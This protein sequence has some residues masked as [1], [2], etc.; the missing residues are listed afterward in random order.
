[1]EA[2]ASPQTQT[3]SIGWATPVTLL[4]GILLLPTLRWLG[5]RPR[6]GAAVARER[7]SPAGGSH[8]RS[9]RSTPAHGSPDRRRPISG[10]ATTGVKETASVGSAAA[11]MQPARF[12]TPSIVDATASPGE[13]ADPTSASSNCLEMLGCRFQ[14]EAPHAE[15][16][17]SALELVKRVQDLGLHLGEVVVS[18]I[19]IGL[20]NAESGGERPVFAADNLESIMRGD[21]HIGRLPERQL[22]AQLDSN[23]VQVRKAPDADGVQVRTRHPLTALEDVVQLASRVTGFDLTAE[24]GISPAVAE[25]LDTTYALAVAA[26]IEALRHAGLIDSPPANAPLGATFDKSFWKLSRPQRDETGVVFAASFPALDSLV[27]E[28]ARSMAARLH[29]AKAAAREEWRVGLRKV[30]TRR[31]EEAAAAAGGARGAGKPGGA[32]SPPAAARGL[33][34]GAKADG[35]TS[36]ASEASELELSQLELDAEPEGGELEGGGG[37]E[38]AAHAAAISEVCEWVHEETQGGAREPPDGS[39]SDSTKEGRLGFG[40]DGGRSGLVA[41]AKRAELRRALSQV[42]V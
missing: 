4:V 39:V 22:Q 35:A 5:L 40:C 30:L 19:S 26:G 16:V 24:F 29:A 2:L 27:E 3:F 8:L 13:A 23:V 6:A 28:L 34:G 21:N 25:T 31:K 15:R 1:M 38:A 17:I 10:D 33:S 12:Q 18:G 14:A 37:V 20:P 11:A 32:R 9:R 42:R 7:R 41:S 36:V